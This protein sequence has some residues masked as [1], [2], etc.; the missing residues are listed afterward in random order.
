MK[1]YFPFLIL[2]VLILFSSCD[3]LTDAD[4]ATLQSDDEI[5]LDSLDDIEGALKSM[6]L[7]IDGKPLTH[8]SI[9]RHTFFRGPK[10][11][12]EEMVSRNVARAASWDDDRTISYDMGNVYID[13]NELHQRTKKYNGNYISFLSNRWRHFYDD[14]GGGFPYTYEENYPYEWEV[15]GSEY[16]D[17][18]TFTT[19]SLPD[20][21]II[22]PEH[23]ST[24][25]IQNDLTIEISPEDEDHTIVVMLGAVKEKRAG[26]KHSKTMDSAHYEYFTETNGTV[27]IPSETLQEYA[28]QNKFDYLMISVSRIH[29]DEELYNENGILSIARTGK[30]LRVYIE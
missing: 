30:Q 11:G 9:S 22:S 17:P 14:N 1:Y 4:D 15:T 18:I 6:G 28:A 29:V 21:D 24:I 3:F 8:F 13:G 5:I 26:R 23:D 7:I 12:E 10:F 2:P 27:V 25:D 19:V 20:I 16:F